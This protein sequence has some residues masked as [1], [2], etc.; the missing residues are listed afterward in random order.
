M[1]TKSAAM[2]ALTCAFLSATAFA[3]QLNAIKVK[4]MVERTLSGAPTGQDAVKLSFVLVN[5]DGTLQMERA[6]HFPFYTGERFKAKL[7]SSRNGTLQL[8]NINP[9]GKATPFRVIAVQAGVPAYYPPEATNVLEFAN[10]TGEETLRVTFTPDQVVNTQVQSAATST[11]TDP[12]SL[13]G[14]ATSPADAPVGQPATHAGMPQPTR[15]SDYFANVSGKA[16]TYSKDMREVVLE[17]PQSTLL[18]RP[19]GTGNLQFDVKVMHRN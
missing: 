1:K 14:L 15:A 12:V 4:D 5:K 7:L 16:Y 10:L 13:Y 17:S 19:S 9:A 2:V 6:A 11:G 3:Q 8:T 18:V